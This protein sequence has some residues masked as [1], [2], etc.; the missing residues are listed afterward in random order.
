M[1]LSSSFFFILF[2][3]LFFASCATHKREVTVVHYNIKE[4]D[5][6]KIKSEHPQIGLVQKVI[7][8]HKMDLFS[9]NEIQYDLPGVPNKDYQSEAPKS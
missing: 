3:L 4:L 7:G 2:F 1:N 5:S 6:K 8:L 9:V